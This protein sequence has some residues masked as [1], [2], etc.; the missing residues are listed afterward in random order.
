MARYLRYELEGVARYG[1]LDGTTITPL[2]GTFPDFRPSGDPTIALDAVRLLAPVEPTRIVSAGPGFKC[3]FPD[4]A[5]YPDMPMFWHKPLAA[6]NHPEGV[7]E[8]PTDAYPGINHEAELG[9][10]IGK[11][12]KCVSPEQAAGHIFG[13]TCYNDVTRGDFYK[14]GAFGASVYFAYGKTYDGFAPIGPWIVTDLDTGNLHIE[15]RINGEVRQSHSTSDRLFSPEQIVSF[16]SH[17][18]TLNPGDVISCGSP[19][20]MTWM[21]HG[22]VCE[23]EIE[24]IGIL[25][26]HVRMRGQ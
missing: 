14:E 4:P 20:G 23:V 19:P 10:V 15:C 12:A 13:Y 17:M 25:R 7:I 2:A 9:I 21:H 24:G 22:D 26:N 16:L 11:R 3:S 18:G 8:L 1:K 5:H 6:L